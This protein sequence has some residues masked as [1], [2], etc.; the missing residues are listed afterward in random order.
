MQRESLVCNLPKRLGGLSLADLQ[1]GV[2]RFYNEPFVAL[3]MFHASGSHSRSPLRAVS[4][5][6][7]GE[8]EWGAQVSVQQG[9]SD[10]WDWDDCPSMGKGQKPWMVPCLCTC[11]Q[12]EPDFNKPWCNHHLW[13][14]EHCLPLACVHFLKVSLSSFCKSSSKSEACLPLACIHV[15]R[16]AWAHFTVVQWSSST[17]WELL[18]TCWAYILSSRAWAYVTFVLC[19]I[20]NVAKACFL[21]FHLAHLLSTRKGF[22]IFILHT[23]HLQGRV[24]VISSCTH[25]IY[26]EGFL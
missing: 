14:A 7:T 26:K 15:S 18:A 11:T 5:W 9:W 19:C 2:H 24:S 6:L 4:V 17:C 23:Q 10:W 13:H 12:G 21:R 25:N 16:W 3:L 1:Q 22:C 20:Q 8:G